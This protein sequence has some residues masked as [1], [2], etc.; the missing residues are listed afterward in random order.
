MAYKHVKEYFKKVENMFI[1]MVN[2]A[3]EFDDAY[4]EGFL[5]QEQIDNANTLLTPIKQNYERLAYIMYLFNMPNRSKKARKY[6]N[7]NKKISNAL[8]DSN[9]ECIIKECEDSLKYFKEYI[10]TLQQEEK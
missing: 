5:T 3:K 7:S 4:K 9:E 6:N 1:E 8:R 2:N 10:K